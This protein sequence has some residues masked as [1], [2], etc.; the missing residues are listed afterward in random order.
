MSVTQRD[1]LMSEVASM[2]VIY[3]GNN[4]LPLNPD[5]AVRLT[6]AIESAIETYMQMATRNNP[7]PSVN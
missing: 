6:T 3:I 1:P 7:Q 2:A 4:W 5:L